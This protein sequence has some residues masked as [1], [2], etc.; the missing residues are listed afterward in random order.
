VTYARLYNLGNYEHERIE[1][2][3][4][5]EENDATAAYIAAVATVES[6]HLRLIESR[7]APVAGPTPK[8][9]ATQKQRNYIAMLQDELGWHSEQ[10]A[11]YAKEQRIDL[12][13][14]TS[15]EASQIINDMKAQLN[16][17]PPF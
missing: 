16:P 8:A 13:E 12:V 14:M 15:Y 17:E 5:V 7:R 3:I 2:T 6:E 11:Q 9:P 4:D 10:M 1:V